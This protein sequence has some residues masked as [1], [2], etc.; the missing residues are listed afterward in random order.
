MLTKLL[1]FSRW[2]FKKLPD[3]TFP[4]MKDFIYFDTSPKSLF[5]R[6]ANNQRVT[7]ADHFQNVVLIRFEAEEGADLIYKPG[8]VLNIRPWNSK[9][10]ISQFFQILETN[11]LIDKDATYIFNHTNGKLHLTGSLFTL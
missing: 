6:V 9:E 11:E 7:A 3:I 1:I 2:S 4:E 8:D 5:V 10:H